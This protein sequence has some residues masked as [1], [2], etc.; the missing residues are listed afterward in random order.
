MVPY[1]TS[2]GLVKNSKIHD[3]SVMYNSPLRYVALVLRA[4][5]ICGRPPSQS[6]A[7]SALELNGRELEPG[8]AMN[9]FISNPERK[10]ERTDADA[11]K[12][13]LYVA[14][15]SKFTAKSDLETLFKPVR[16]PFPIQSQALMVCLSSEN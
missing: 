6:S 8:H 11:D 7:E 15:L 4:R 1:L 3:V 12:R 5:T 14:G 16:V 13:E 10:K 9:V 2:G